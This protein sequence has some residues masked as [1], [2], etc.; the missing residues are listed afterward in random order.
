MP[1]RL[2]LRPPG[3]H[4]VVKLGFP[5]ARIARHFESI[6]EMFPGNLALP[7]I[8][9]RPGDRLPFGLAPGHSIRVQTL[10]RSAQGNHDIC[11]MSKNDTFIRLLSNFLQERPRFFKHFKGFRKTLLLRE[12]GADIA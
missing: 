11:R 8:W 12:D 10:H 5:A 1:A 3:R 6:L 2:R 4:A 9:L 7:E